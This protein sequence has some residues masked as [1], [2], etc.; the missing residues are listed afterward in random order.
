MSNKV[1]VG[2]L[3]WNTDDRLLREA[4]EVHGTVVEASVVTDR[5][6]GR[7][8]GF[9]F[10]TFEDAAGA[11]AS[12]EAMNG[13]ELDGRALRVDLAADRPRT[14][15]PHGSGGPGGRPGGPPGKGRG[16]GSRRNLRA[17]K[18]SF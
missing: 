14:G 11:Q 13:K 8:R 9:G 15:G 6:T 5:D 2:G 12:L 4:F 17:R 18:R 16:K 10:V 7:S 1:F 3:S